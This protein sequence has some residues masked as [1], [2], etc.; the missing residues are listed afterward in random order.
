MKRYDATRGVRF[1]DTFGSIRSATHT[2]K[3]WGAILIGQTIGSP[4]PKTYMLD[5]PFRDGSIDLTNA[6]STYVFYKNRKLT[7]SLKFIDVYERWSYIYSMVMTELHGKN[8]YI[9]FD[10]DNRFFYY[11][12]VYVDPF[13]SN[14]LQGIITINADVEP[15]KTEIDLLS[16]EITV[17]NEKKSAW[18]WDTFS[19]VD[20]VIYDISHKINK[21]GSFTV[22]NLE[23]RV[24]PSIKTDKNITITYKDESY[25]LIG[26]NAYH[27]APF[28]IDPKE[29]V[30]K[31]TVTDGSEATVS[32]IR[33][34]GLL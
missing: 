31:V 1:S 25:S 32:L 15:Y 2:Y 12:R 22:Y 17:G 23:K 29:S 5:V 21:S 4:E 7:I 27:Y 9:C 16:D 33:R 20:G 6:Y 18:I 3:K 24:K 11:G 30:I 10:E 26:D 14:R 13:N 28:F 8:K 19:F 34:G